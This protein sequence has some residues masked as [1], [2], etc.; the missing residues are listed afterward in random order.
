MS[1]TLLI[2]L[3]TEELPPKALK[4]LCQSFASGMA[5]GLRNANLSF[6]AVT[7]FGS[8]RRLAVQIE[9]LAEQQ[10][11]QTIE[12]LGPNVAAAFQPDGQPTPAAA[13]F[14]RSCGVPFEQLERVA[15]DKGERL[16]YRA[17]RPGQATTALVPELVRAALDRLPIPKRMRW[18]ARR[19]EFV[20][21]VHWLVMLFGSD[22]I[23]GEVLGLQAGRAT[24][25]HRFHSNQPLSLATAEQYQAMLLEHKVIASFEERR[26]II[27]QQVTELGA[28]LGG[29]AIIDDGLLDEVTGLVEWP[30]A[31]AG[32]FEERFLAVPQEALISS[33]QEHQ[34]YFHVVDGEGRLLPAFITVA[35]IESADPDQVIAGNERVI[36]PRLSD[37]A[38]FFETD[39]QLPLASR[40]EQLRSIVFQEQLGTVYAKTTRIARL[41][42]LIAETIGGSSSW[43]R[44]AGELSKADLLSGMVGEFDDMQGIAGSYYAR[45]DGEPDEVALALREHYQPRFAGD[46]LPT[47]ATGIAVAMADRLD[48]LVGI[49]GIGQPPTGS[50]DPFA[51]RRAA[52]GVLRMII[53]K[54][55]D[56]DLQALLAAAQRGYLEDAPAIASDPKLAGTVLNYLIERLRAWYEEEGIAAE[57]FQAVSAR[58]LSHPL[59]IDQRVHA[60]HHFSQLAEAEA[61]AAANKRVSNILAKQDEAA[62]P[63]LDPALLQE[64]AERELAEALAREAEVV[65]PLFAARRYREALEQL[66]ALRAPV[67]AFFDNVMV[68]VDDE[69]LR[70][71]R[72]ALLAQLRALFLEVADISLLAVSSK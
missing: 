29:S 17:V 6:G 67:D 12:K 4:A 30:V 62:L 7:G 49:F 47:T 1:R 50:K 22:V 35:N 59:D 53:E 70:N 8:P 21:P 15:T 58:R 33:M 39:L 52:L 36:R 40:R 72:L 43:A 64:P 41:A 34:K 5:D 45:H 24:W 46:A 13:G 20:R 37:A 61:L 31:L 42:E 25:G 9:A 11:D 51:L 27:R 57:V 19:T 23:E 28:S 3:G 10:P 54:G 26:A 66:A 44:R 56:V 55:Y 38:F 68:M 71:N 2:E 65:R 14:A 48:T 60:V 18:G 69:P 16:A 63:A 32:R